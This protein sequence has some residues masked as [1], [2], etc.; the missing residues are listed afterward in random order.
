MELSISTDSV[1]I[2]NDNYIIEDMLKDFNVINNNH[3]NIYISQK[4]GEEILFGSGY[5]ERDMYSVNQ[6][7][8]GSGTRSGK[9]YEIFNKE[10]GYNRIKV[11]VEIENINIFDEI[12]D[13]KM[14]SQDYLRSKRGVN[15]ENGYE[16]IKYSIDHDRIC[17]LNDY[18]KVIIK[19]DYIDIIF[20]FRELY[21]FNNELE[22]S[23]I[24]IKLNKK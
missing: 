18:S 2:N 3:V 22:L 17:I 14:I 7:Y 16:E 20:R 8:F 5:L 6:K 9:E 1:M 11:K 12:I 4:E 10:Y 15:C 24:M 21:R 13:F 23:S 19:N